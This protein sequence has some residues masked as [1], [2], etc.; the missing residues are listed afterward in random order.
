MVGKMINGYSSG[1]SLSNSFFKVIVLLLLAFAVLALVSGVLAAS[2]TNGNAT[3]SSVQGF[4]NSGAGDNELVLEEGDYNDLLKDIN[5][6]RSLN[7][8]GNGKVNIQSS[9]GGNLF[10]VTAVSVNISNLNIMG[11]NTAIRSSTGGLQVI[12][13]NITTND[14][15]INLLGSGDLTGILLANNT[16][17]SSVNN[18]NYGAVY[19]NTVFGYKVNLSLLNN[20]ITANNN[21]GNGVRSY[22]QGCQNVF[23]LENNNITGN[24]DG[25]ALHAYS[26]NNT[27]NFNYNNI[28]G[29][30]DGVDLYAYSS[31][32]T[33]NFNYNNIT[34]NSGTGVYLY[35]SSSNNTINFSNNNI[36]GNYDG[37]ALYAYSSNNTINFNNNNI[38]GNDYGV[39][40]HASSS[41]NTVKFVGNEIYGGQYGLYVYVWQIFSGFSFVNNIVASNDVGLYFYVDSSSS[42]SN[43]N[44]TGNFINT[45]NYGLF[46][47]GSGSVNIR[48]NYNRILSDVGLDFTNA[49]DAGSSF[50]YNWWGVNDIASKIVGFT[51]NNHYILNITNLTSLHNRHPGDRVEFAF[52]VLNTTHKNEG[53]ENLPY[54]EINGTFNGVEYKTNR[55]NK[56]EHSFHIANEGLQTLD[57]SVDEASDLITFGATKLATNSTIHTTENLRTGKTSTIY[58]ILTDAD[59]NPVANADVEVIID[60]K[61]HKAKTNADGKWSL[62][63][64]S[65]NVGKVFVHVKCAGSERYYASLNETSFEVRKGKVNID[66]NVDVREDGSVEVTVKVTDEDGDPIANHDVKIELDGEHVG[67]VITDSNGVGNLF[68]PA[69]KIKK[70]EHTITAVF[71]HPNYDLES[72]STNFVEPGENPTNKTNKTNNTSD[73]SVAVATMKNTG[74]PAILLVF[75]AIFGLLTY[76]RKK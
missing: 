44:V 26:S 36:T 45:T 70:G 65:T 6:S 22:L 25:V 60:G 39:Y 62:S 49:V 3:S 31:N 50:D 63:Y 59:G 9:S 40:L 76:R 37:V 41:N 38:I 56:F 48:V 66:L 71:N 2:F 19:I 57:A 53:V 23:V 1:Y 17:N 42:L 61:L 33:I 13:N 34:G 14:I 5:V 55:D 7:I 16:I 10:N 20:N 52:L 69:K 74:I 32:N 75:L 18:Y 24:Y 8:R 67:N 28:T 68:I 46:F 11:Y 21:N 15:S 72:V 73:N 47:D 43:V 51:T 54:F 27:I 12:G 4:I 29:N 58:G 35:A 64:K 30:Y